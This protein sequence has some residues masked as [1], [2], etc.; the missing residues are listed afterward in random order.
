MTGISEE[1]ERCLLAYRWPGNIRELENAIERA[2]VLGQSDMV[3][4]EDLPETILESADVP[5]RPGRAAN[6]GDAT[7]ARADPD[8]VA[9]IGRRPQ[10]GRRAAQD[11]PEFAAPAD[12]RVELAGQFV[13][14]RLPYFS[15]DAAFSG[16][17]IVD[18][19]T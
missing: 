17:T 1:A 18:S 2:V 6:V 7:Q 13:G 12:P 3:L 19:S 9:R 15:I 16:V 10:R 14:A 8:G 11:P 4:P 5:A